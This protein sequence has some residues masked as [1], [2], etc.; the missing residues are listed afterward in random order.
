MGLKTKLMAI[1]SLLSVMILAVSSIAGYTFTK[2]QVQQNI[3]NELKATETAGLNK[4]DGW[5]I[6][7]AK[8]L[9][10]TSA[11]LK[12][13]MGDEEPSVANLAG[14]KIA[15][16][17][18]SDVYVGTES[19]KMIDGS[20]WVAPKDYDPRIRAWYKTAIQENRLVFTDPYFDQVTKKMA[21]AVAMPIIDSTGKTSGII[22]QD[23]LLK[24]LVSNVGALNLNGQGN[25]LLI[26]KKGLLLAYPDTR[27]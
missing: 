22:S 5:L 4:L 21:V 17:E 2:K 6:S 18:L 11:T 26:D 1:F 15:D 19:G 8:I 7:K 24:T 20:G 3:Q 23:I 13:S 27:Y 25:A 12:S 9:E 16:K 14:F 10:M